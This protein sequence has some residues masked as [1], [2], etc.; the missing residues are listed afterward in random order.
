MVA[1]TLEKVLKYQAGD[2]TAV[3]VAVIAMDCAHIAD[4]EFGNNNRKLKTATNGVARGLILPQN[5]FPG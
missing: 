2:Q 3:P 5:Q 4:L 1:G